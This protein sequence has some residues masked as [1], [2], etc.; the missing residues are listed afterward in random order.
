MCI[1]SQQDAEAFWQFMTNVTKM[2]KLQKVE[3]EINLDRTKTVPDPDYDNSVLI[4][5]QDYDWNFMLNNESSD[6]YRKEEFSLS[7]RVFT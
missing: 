4:V 3:I 5:P 7:V 6:Y 2:D 1:K